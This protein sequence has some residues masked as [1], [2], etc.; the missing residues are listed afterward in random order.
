MVRKL[1]LVGDAAS[2]AWLSTDASREIHKQNGDSKMGT[3]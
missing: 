1:N 2:I 3:A